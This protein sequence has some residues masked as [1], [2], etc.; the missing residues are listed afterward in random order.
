MGEGLYTILHSILQNYLINLDI[1]IS[2]FL[3]GPAVVIV[4]CTLRSDLDQEVSNC[5]CFEVFQMELF[6]I[7]PQTGLGCVL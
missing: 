1:N 7:N 3:F 5:G 6:K 4:P 2:S